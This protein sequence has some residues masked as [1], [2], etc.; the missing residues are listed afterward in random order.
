[1]S[2]ASR[3]RFAAAASLALVLAACAGARPS[4]SPEAIAAGS[5]ATPEPSPTVSAP[6]LP[7][8]EPT[9]QPSSW[10]M[11]TSTPFVPRSDS[12]EAGLQYFCDGSPWPI[13]ILEGPPSS[14][15]APEIALGAITFGIEW[16]QPTGEWWLVY[17]TKTQRELLGTTDFPSEHENYIHIRVEQWED[18]V[19]RIGHIGGCA[20]RSWIGAERP[21]FFPLGWWIAE[22]DWPM[23]DDRVLHVKARDWCPDTL[24]ERLGKHVIRYGTDRI[25]II[26]AFQPEKR[27]K[28]PCGEGQ[29]T[30]FD[31]EL[32]EP[33][34]DRQLLDAELWPPRDARIPIPVQVFCCG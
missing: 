18:G 29:V 11:P 33:V 1:V 3:I 32:D 9:P 21:G 13:E 19:W 28:P 34:G 25:L 22:K 12:L 26:A 24:S 15:D 10:Q 16:L 7:S 8:A 14:S 23:P 20:V 5:S 17:A 4:A 6:T 30:R 2:S 27:E 31:I